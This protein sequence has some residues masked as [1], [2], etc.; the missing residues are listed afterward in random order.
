MFRKPQRICPPQLSVA[1]PIQRK[2]TV[3]LA[4][5]FFQQIIINIIYERHLPGI[6]CNSVLFA[7]I[8]KKRACTEISLYNF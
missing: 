6:E 7:E 2:K 5:H 1:E 3:L 8:D 4:S